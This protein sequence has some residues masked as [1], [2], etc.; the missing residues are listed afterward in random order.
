MQKLDRVSIRVVIRHIRETI[1]NILRD[2]LFNEIDEKLS[3]RVFKTIDNYLN[4][5][6]SRKAFRNYG[7]VVS[8]TDGIVK[9]LVIIYTNHG[10]SVKLDFNMSPKEIACFHPI[11][12]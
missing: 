4:D 9:I 7:I 11:G 3:R 8:V 5:L 2:M 1:E 6:V 10:E 12:F